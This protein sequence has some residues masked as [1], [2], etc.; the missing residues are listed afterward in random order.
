[1]SCATFAQLYEMVRRLST[2]KIM[3]I[4]GAI[5]TYQ[6]VF[7]WL[8]PFLLTQ[9]AYTRNNYGSPF[10]KHVLTGLVQELMFKFDWNKVTCQWRIQD[11]RRE[12]PTSWG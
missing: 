2:M 6:A 5:L 9:N 10:K 3:W 7:D 8:R 12:V 11:F 1:M 4:F